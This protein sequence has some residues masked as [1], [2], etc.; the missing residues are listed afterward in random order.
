MERNE[1]P[2]VT[3]QYRQGCENLAEVFRF[4]GRRARLHVCESC[5]IEIDERQ[6]SF[7]D[8]EDGYDD[9]GRNIG[10]S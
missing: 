7:E 6:E 8:D 5:A 3:C 9:D 1:V 4:V 10:A 2:Q